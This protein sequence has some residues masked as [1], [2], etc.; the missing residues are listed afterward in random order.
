M[1]EPQ[2]PRNGALRG[3]DAWT[4]V[5]MTNALKELAPEFEDQLLTALGEGSLA[6][7]ARA[8]SNSNE[9]NG[10]LNA[11]DSFVRVITETHGVT[12]SPELAEL[13]RRAAATPG[14]SITTVTASRSFFGGLLRDLDR[15]MGVTTSPEAAITAR[16]V[17]RLDGQA[18]SEAVAGS[19][20]EREQ[21][22][23]LDT[24]VVAIYW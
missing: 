7:L 18:V 15:A 5:K 23:Y 24:E 22:R 4:P 11:A 8:Q 10:L 1:A 12:I 19:D 16:M 6:A 17:A 2:R 9:M 21:P 20:P 3:L 13:G 14:A